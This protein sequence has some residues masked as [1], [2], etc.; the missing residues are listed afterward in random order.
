MHLVVGKRLA[1]DDEKSVG[2]S[3]FDI[4]GFIS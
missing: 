2:H 1:D 4:P 3:G